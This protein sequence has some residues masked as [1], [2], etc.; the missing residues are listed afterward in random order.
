VLG[1][2]ALLP[3]VVTQELLQVVLGET[4]TR[5]GV[6]LVTVQQTLLRRFHTVI[7]ASL[8]LLS[9]G[10][11]LIK[12]R[13]MVRQRFSE[14]DP[15]VPVLA[16]LAGTSL[17]IL[18][19]TYFV[20]GLV[21]ADRVY[22]YTLLFAGP[23]AGLSI[24]A[25]GRLAAEGR[26]SQVGL[27]LGLD[28]SVMIA[29]LLVL[30]ALNSGFAYAV[31]GEPIASDTPFDVDTHSQTYSAA[32]RDAATW[33]GDRI[34]SPSSETRP[35]PLIRPIGANADP[36]IP[37]DRRIYTD[38]YTVALFRGIAPTEYYPVSYPFFKTGPEGV[39][40]YPCGYAYIRERAVVS[41]ANDRAA[42]N[43]YLS[44]AE[45]D[46]VESSADRIYDTGDAVVLKKYSVEHPD[47]WE[48]NSSAQRGDSC[49][50]Q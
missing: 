22:S 3:E 41:D 30:L 43:V 32:E 26:V 36:G 12:G 50:S 35:Q 31:L 38:A 1:L 45:R 34:P 10:G 6:D 44:P 9:G 25:A 47:R 46:V 29:L 7:H 15:Q 21:G 11:L 23:F 16:S 2:L 13:Q 18:F 39:L 19:S 4:V 17:C 42:P 27:N 37:P 40:E 24:H 20:T 8:V 33:L 14:V 49:R 28:R 48:E 5:S